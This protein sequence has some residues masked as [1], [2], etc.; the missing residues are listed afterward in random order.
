MLRSQ[1]TKYAPNE[2]NQ[3]DVQIDRSKTRKNGNRTESI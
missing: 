3:N 1:E 2:Q